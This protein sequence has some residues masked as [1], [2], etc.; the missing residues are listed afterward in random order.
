IGP[1]GVPAGLVIAP[2]VATPPPKPRWVDPTGTVSL[3]VGGVA[4]LC[5]SG[6]GWCR[7][8]APLSLGGLL[9]GVA[10]LVLTRASGRSRLYFPVAGTLTGAAVLFTALV[11]PALL[12]PTYEASRQR[13]APASNTIRQVALSGT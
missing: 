4:L 11:F 6:P 13:S 8:V 2:T 12:G 5:A 3:L 10:A 1:P 7:L 9:V